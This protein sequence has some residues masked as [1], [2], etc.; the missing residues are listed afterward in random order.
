MLRNVTRNCKMPVKILDKWK[1]GQLWWGGWASLHPHRL[2]TP[3]TNGASWETYLA[4]VGSTSRSS[5]SRF[6]EDVILYLWLLLHKT[7]FSFLCFI[8][9]RSE[10][11]REENSSWFYHG[12]I[13]ACQKWQHSFWGEKNHTN[14]VCGEFFNGQT[15]LWIYTAGSTA[16]WENG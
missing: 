4:H 13:W 14:A 5:P 12:W 15:P 9:I 11:E 3:V 6:S 16:T 7:H 8:V 10:G 2:W 1:T